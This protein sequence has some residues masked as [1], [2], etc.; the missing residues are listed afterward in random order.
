MVVEDLAPLDYRTPIVDSGGRPSPQFQRAWD[1]Q[2]RNNALIGVALGNGAPTGAPKGGAEY[3]DTSTT[4]YTVYIGSAGAWHQAGVVAFTDLEDAP[5]AYAGQALALVRVKQTA[6]GVEF[7]SQSAM[8]DSLGTPA[9]GQLL[10][11]VAG[12]WALLTP[13]AVLDGFSSTQGGILYRDVAGWAALAPGTAGNVLTTGGPSANPSWAAGGGGGGGGYE[14]STP[15]PPTTA[16]GSLTAFNNHVTTL[17]TGT[18]AALM[19]LHGANSGIE[20]YEQA[21]PATPY[22]IVCRVQIGGDTGGQAGL[23]LRN[24]TSAKLV[25]L[26]VYMP[27]GGQGGVIN[28]NWTNPTTFNSNIY[29]LPW[30]PPLAQWLR[31]HNDGTNLTFYISFNGSEWAQLSAVTLASF[32][33]SADK[34]GIYGLPPGGGTFQ[35]AFF[36]WFKAALP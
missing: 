14:K 19:N 11:R 29:V 7:A 28:Q 26:G 2:R 8:L 3:V 32:I 34:V 9:N 6:D 5:H 35:V 18:D 17:V 31:I 24:S 27:A 23:V 21:A 4:P 13:S 22:D 20:S 33:S 16:G 15:T 36:S 12:V 30:P 1:K 25:T 10:Q